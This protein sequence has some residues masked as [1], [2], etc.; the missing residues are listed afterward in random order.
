[1][2]IA[3]A[4]NKLIYELG[5]TEPQEIDIESIACYT[6]IEVR[7]ASLSGCE[8]SLIGFRNR[9]IVTIE[10]ESISQRQRFSIGHEIG[11][12]ILHRGRSFTC[13]INDQ[14]LAIEQKPAEEK[15]ADKF[16]AEL[17]MPKEIFR[18]YTLKFKNH[19]LDSVKE[20]SNI[21]NVSNL[22]A[23]LRLIDM[24]AAP[25]I[26]ICHSKQG[27]I[28]FR[29][30]KIAQ[31]WFPKKELHPDSFA[32]DVLYKGATQV[33]PQKVGAEAWFDKWNANRF[34]LLEHSCKYGDN[35]LTLLT[36]SA[37]MI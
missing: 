5:I 34:E 21:F 24:D 12:W 25:L 4:A 28:W 23:A 17:L 9:A 2:T 27:R 18:P 30:S 36:L 13:R 20:L 6:G 15:V 31:E 33:R 10:K 7:Y 26:L 3:D 22:A 8:A 37:E 11:H 35:V 1:M 29:A 19:S 14:E 16:S 32:M